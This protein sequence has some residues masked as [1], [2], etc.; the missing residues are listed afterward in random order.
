MEICLSGRMVAAD[1]ALRLGLVTT[2][3]PVDQLSATVDAMVDNILAQPGSS[4]RATKTVLS[5]RVSR[6][7]EEQRAIERNAQRGLLRG[8][9]AGHA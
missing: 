2:V 5:Y 3:T 9:A 1:E 6:D 4:V 7:R 8:L